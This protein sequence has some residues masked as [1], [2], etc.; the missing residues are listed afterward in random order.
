MDGTRDYHTKSERDRHIPYDITH[1]WNLKYNT[2]EPVYKKE[3]Y[4]QTQ[5]TDLWLPTRRGKERDGLH[6]ELGVSRC[7]Q[8]HLE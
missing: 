2:N 4:S 7:K 8:L 6:C 5:R 3:T 1:K